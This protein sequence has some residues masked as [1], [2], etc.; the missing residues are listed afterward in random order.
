MKML[1]LS[2]R[3]YLAL[4][5]A[6]SAISAQSSAHGAVD[7][8][9][10]DQ[11]YVIAT[12]DESTY[13]PRGMG[14]QDLHMGDHP[15]AWTRCIGDGRSFYSAIG[16]RPESYSE[17]HNVKL[18]EQAILWAADAGATHCKAGKEN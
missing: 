11:P 13:S 5:C 6:A 7:C 16:H 9:L 10:R 14:E 1:S 8:P 3:C 12:L 15:I 18:F 4:L 2:A 17:P